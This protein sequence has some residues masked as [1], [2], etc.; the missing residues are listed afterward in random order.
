MGSATR[1]ALADARTALGS[2]DITDALEAGQQLFSAGR[3][4]GDSAQLRSVLADPSVA[5]TEKT[6]VIDSLFSSFGTPAR[7]LL[8]GL[9]ASRWSTQDQ[10]LAGIEEIGIRAVAR[11]APSGLSIESELFAFGAAVSSDAELELAVGSKLGSNSA[12]A[13][14][15]G[16][17]LKDKSSEQSLAIL[18]H[19]VQQPRGRRIGGL[20]R[21][22]ASIVADQAGLAVATITSAAPISAAQVDRLRVGLSKSYGRDL[23]VNLVV[24]PSI[25]GGIRVQVGDDVIDGSVSTRINELRLK[26]AS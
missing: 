17:L 26:L 21:T 7:A 15:V 8:S 24:D 6:A 13:A 3:V 18:N 23:E 20:I 14:L 4:V 22:A 11:S 25:V 5:A 2:L 12:K 10:L 19:L 9:V 16:A 1:V